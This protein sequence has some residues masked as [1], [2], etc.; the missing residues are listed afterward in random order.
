MLPATRVTAK[1]LL[2]VY[3]CPVI[4]FAVD[5]AIDAGAER[6]V[7]VVSETKAAIREF[8]GEKAV[9][10]TE[11]SN[12]TGGTTTP[13]EIVYVT[14]HEP[15]GLG[16]A[17]L[18]CKDVT[19]PGPFGVILPDD[20]I[21]E[22]CCLQE[23]AENYHA[24][25]MIAA[26]KVPSID[27]CK[28]GIFSFRGSATDVCIP[29]TGIVEKPPS[30]QAASSIAAVG[31]YILQPMIFDVLAH[32]PTGAGG[33]LQLTDAI[34]IATHSMPLT[35]FRFSGTRFDCGNHDGLLAASSARQTAFKASQM[36]TPL[37]ERDPNGQLRA[38]RRTRS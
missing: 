23:M 8:L 25:H 26:M 11:T 9:A 36:N 24:G 10:S 31:R 22:R 27:T 16:H 28:Y 18:C 32:T 6:I 3:D 13:A 7:V 30:G 38:T 34:A 2:P 29:V 1:E 19:L 5:E 4:Q 17:V 20:I 15:L 35:A 37:F 33:E 21:L 12:S 14:Q